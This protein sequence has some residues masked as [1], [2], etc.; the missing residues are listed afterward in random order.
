MRKDILIMC[1]SANSGHPGGS[2][3]AI[4]ILVCLY[5]GFLKH[6]PKNP[7]AEDRDRFVL[8]KGHACPALYAVLADCGYFKHKALL[9]FRK[10][11]SFLQGHPSRLDTPGIEFSTGSLGQGFSGAVGMALGCMLDKKKN[12]IYTMLGDGECDEGQVW[13]AALS[14][15]HYKLDNLIAIVDVNGLQIDGFTK[16]IMNTEPIAE[17]FQAFNWN[18]IEIDGHDYKQ[19]IAAFEAAQH[20]KNHKP[21]VIIARTIKGKGVSFMENKVEWHG[22]APNDEELVIALKELE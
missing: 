1:H 2:L 9:T 21:T 17:K 15:A 6:D 11:D 16:D 8:S 13:E 14:A 3:S 5:Y 4:D 12:T 10:I 7:K 22:K 20:R 19:I 18:V